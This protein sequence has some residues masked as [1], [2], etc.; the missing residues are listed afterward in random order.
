MGNYYKQQ[1]EHPKALYYYSACL[2][3]KEKIKGKASLDAAHVYNNIGMVY[4]QMEDY[5][6]A[7]KYFKM[8]LIIRV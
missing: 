2:D 7:E 3:I 8:C 5:I 4:R 1:L 6:E